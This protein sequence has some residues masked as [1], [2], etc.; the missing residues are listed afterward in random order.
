MRHSSD[1][2]CPLHI[3]EVT[4]QQNYY[5]ATPAVNVN[6]ILAH[7]LR[8]GS[9][10]LVHLTSD[11]ELAIY[12]VH[13]HHYQYRRG[14]L[15]AVFAVNQAMIQAVPCADGYTHQGDIPQAKV[16][17]VALSQV[18]RPICVIVTPGPGERGDDSL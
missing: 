11:P 15:I 3:E 16:K 13:A 4:L 14:S 12:S 5:H 9:D 17:F 6:S 7:G 2:T 1:S 18:K 8:A 10:G